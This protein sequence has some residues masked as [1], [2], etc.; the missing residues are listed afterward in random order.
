M[1]AACERPARVCLC[2]RIPDIHTR[3]RVVILQHPRE[4]TVPI[5]TARLAE[6]SL[7]SV[8]RHVGV[9]FASSRD[10][11]AALADTA[12]PAV[13]LFPGE[14]SRDLQREPPSGPLTLIVIDGT[15]WQAEKILKRNPELGR[16]PRYHLQPSEPSRYRIRRAPARDCISTIEAIVEALSVLE[17]PE[18]RVRA[19][20]QPFDT[21]VEQQ[22]HFAAARG[23]R[24]HRPNK[25][26]RRQ[27][28]FTLLNQRS[29]D[30]VVGY[31]E[32]NAW[33]RGSAL[34]AHPELV[35]WA[36]ERL[37]T[38]ERFEAFIAPTNALSPTFQCHN[39]LSRES[40]LAGESPSSFAE[41]WRAFSRPDDV[42]CTWGFYAAELLVARLESRPEQLDVRSLAMLHL[43]RKSGDVSDCA[44]TLGATAA[45]PW[46]SG[47]TGI[48]LSALTAVT[49]AILQATELEPKCP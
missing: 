31:G 41:R 11:Q 22:L 27:R 42:L 5:G 19:A 45:P 47:R 14:G 6:L 23:E 20:L 35:H 46:V 40:V 7:R 21:L 34:G 25:S 1:C 8:E 30:L 33:P 16:L 29:T 32:A 10:V 36:A 37:L 9:T 2:S 3:T 24:R 26:P 48:R 44:A 12:A 15:W 18:L 38:G 49:R 4:S 43:R 39:G 13:L 17:A 28:P